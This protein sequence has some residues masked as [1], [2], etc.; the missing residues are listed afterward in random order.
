L[1]ILSE[2]V[3]L[4]PNTDRLQQ[5]EDFCQS[6]FY[7]YQILTS[8]NN[9]KI[10][11]ELV[12]LF[13]NTDCLQKFEDFVRGCT[14]QLQKIKT[15]WRQGNVWFLLY[16]KLSIIS[17]ISWREHILYIKLPIY[18]DWLVLDI[19]SI[20]YNMFQWIIGIR[21]NTFQLFLLI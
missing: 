19:Y 5:F 20:D 16:A 10:L 4:L 6:L 3:L 9:L 11:W 21:L 17:F 2:L 1:K 13:P 18:L 8:F 14:C 7:F 12:L 15:I